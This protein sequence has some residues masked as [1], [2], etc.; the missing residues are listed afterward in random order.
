MLG[1]DLPTPDSDKL[2]G[3]DSYMVRAPFSFFGGGLESQKMS[4]K[5]ILNLLL[6]N[7]N[8]PLN[9]PNNSQKVLQKSFKNNKEFLTE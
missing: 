4:N 8:L 5:I 6:K 1:R 3:L 9:N 7:F 2:N